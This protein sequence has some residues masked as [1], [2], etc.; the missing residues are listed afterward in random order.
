M[1]LFINFF[2]LSI[3]ERWIERTIYLHWRLSFNSSMIEISLIPTQ[4]Y[5]SYHKKNMYHIC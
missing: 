5:C 2:S 3:V 1:R 4:G